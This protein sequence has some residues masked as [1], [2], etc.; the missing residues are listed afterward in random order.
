[1]L[2]MRTR[3]NTARMLRRS[4]GPV[5]FAS[6]ACSR[7]GDAS[8]ALQRSQTVRSVEEGA[9][10]RGK[11][12]PLA[13]PF[14]LEKHVRVRPPSTQSLEFGHPVFKVLLLVALISQPDIP[15]VRGGLERRRP[16]VRVGHTQR[17]VAGAKQLVHVGVEPGRVAELPGAA[18]VGREQGQ[19]VAQA[20]GVLLEVWRQLKQDWTELQLPPNLDR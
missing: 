12:R 6:R 14:V 15:E 8:E 2:L 4:E 11:L 20:L 19:D 17:R 9:E 1:M 10:L 16:L 13:L 18:Q 7:C 5:G 3:C